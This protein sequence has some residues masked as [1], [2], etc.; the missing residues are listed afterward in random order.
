MRSDTACH[1]HQ[2]KERSYKA[3]SADADRDAKGD[4]ERQMVWTDDRV[5]DAG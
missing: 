5:T 1:C 3:K 2:K 4:Q